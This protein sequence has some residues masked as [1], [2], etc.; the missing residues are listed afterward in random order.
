M[1]E[2]RLSLVI[3]SRIPASG[4]TDIG[5]CIRERGG[6]T[7][8]GHVTGVGQL[9]ALTFQKTVQCHICIRKKIAGKRHTFPLQAR[10]CQG[11]KQALD[12]F[13]SLRQISQPFVNDLA[14]GQAY[15]LEAG[16]AK[17]DPDPPSNGG[18][19]GYDLS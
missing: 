10:S 3:F 14:P 15:F 9:A 11:Y 13:F 19:A 12:R 6:L 1:R 2:S 16:I 4:E 8:K 17:P 18:C 5:A 7:Q